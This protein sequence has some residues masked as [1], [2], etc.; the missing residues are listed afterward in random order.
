MCIE[1]FTHKH[2]AGRAGRPFF[3]LR[4]RRGEDEASK[5]FTKESIGVE[6]EGK[7]ITVMHSWLI[8]TRST[9]GQAAQNLI[10]VTNIAMR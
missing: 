7:G 2:I 3:V 1:Q 4:R 6:G 5:C 10:S 8:Q 9:L